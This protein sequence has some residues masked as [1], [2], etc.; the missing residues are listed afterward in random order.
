MKKILLIVTVLIFTIACA[1]K[2][3]EETQE[4]PTVETT[5]VTADPQDLLTKEWRLKELN[6]KNVVL[7]STF[8][9]YP[10][11]KFADLKTAS[12]NLGCNGFGAKVEFIG[13]NGI[14]LSEIISTEMA[15]G[16]MN[17]ENNFNEALQNTSTYIVSENMLYLN[18]SENITVAILE[19]QGNQ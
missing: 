2:K 8:T 4:K 14:K 9:K 16:N 18:N 5:E 1:D 11:I 15:C 3:K 7:D 6:G 19:S 17:I 12:G 10:Y 13:N